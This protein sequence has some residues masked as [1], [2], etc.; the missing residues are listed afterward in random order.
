VSDA[1]TAEQ[2]A[3]ITRRQTERAA[4]VARELQTEEAERFAA[5]AAS[6]LEGPGVT[7]GATILHS[8]E[9]DPMPE[10][11]C[12]YVP[13]EQ[14][15]VDRYVDGIHESA[16][17]G[18]TRRKDAGKAAGFHLI[19][20]RPL[21]ELARLYAIGAAKYKPRGWEAGMEWSR[22]WDAMER[23]LSKYIMGERF[24]AVDGQHHL[25]S[26]AWACF[27]LMEYE[28]THP[29]LDDLRRPEDVGP[30]LDAIAGGRS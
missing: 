5:W 15:V 30:P 7:P 2:L 3:E 26:V 18:D 1:L 24:D 29:E 12:D 28:L 27:A 14:R 21:A 11:I 23:H 20:R 22:V 25:A 9:V 19:P 16:E 4:E 8:D 10:D 6:R 13:Q 17:Y